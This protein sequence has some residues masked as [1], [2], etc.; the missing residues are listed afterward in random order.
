[1]TI[2]WKSV[3][4]RQSLRAAIF[5]IIGI[6]AGLGALDAAAREAG[7]EGT[8]VK[9]RTVI[10]AV[11][12]SWP[13][14]YSTDED[15]N[16]AGFAIDVMN[17]IAERAGIKVTYKVAEN[18]AGVSELM[19]RGE[20][21]LVP[22][23][24]VT[25]DRAANF[26][27]TIPVETF[28]VSIFVRSDTHDINGFADLA[29]R[30]V[31]VVRYNMGETLLRPRPEIKSK[32][33]P[34]LRV[35]LFELL[36]GHDD[37]LVF[38]KP[39][40]LR[41]AREIGVEDRIKTVGAPLQEIKR[42][43]RIQKSEPALAAALNIATEAFVGT[44]EY[45]R[46]Y[47]KWYGK[48]EPFWTVPR[49]VWG[50]VGLLAAVLL[51]GAGW[52]YRLVVKWGRELAAIIA[53]KESSEVALRVSESRFKDFAGAASDWFWEMG[54]DLRFTYHSERYFEI[55]GFRPEDMV[56][57]T[58]AHDVDAN[59]LA[60]D[61]E[62]WAVH[63]AE[64][65][66]HLPFKDFEFAFLV[67]D[68]SRRY[69]RVNGRP[70]FA[71]DGGFAG[72]RGTG[73]DVTESKLAQNALRDS[74]TSFRELV[75]SSLQ[76]VSVLD[77][78]QRFF[79]NRAYAEMLG[80][81]SPDDV[82]KLAR[83][84]DVF[85][86][87]EQQRLRDR[88]PQ[89][90]A[91]GGK[92][93]PFEADM[94]RKDGSIITVLGMGRRIQWYGKAAVLSF[95]VD[96]TERKRAEEALRDSERNFRAIAEGS[97]VSLLI[98]RRSDGTIL[99]AN[100]KVGPVLGLPTEAFKG[101]KI[102]EFFWQSDDRENRAATLEAQG[103]IADAPLE[104]RRADG[105]RISTIHCLQ[106]IN[107]AGENAILGSFQDVTDRL[108]LEEQLRQAQK[109][110][111]I[112]QLTGGVAHDF[113]NLLAVIMGNLELLVERAEA[114]S[115]IAKFA[116]RALAATGRG[117]N[118]THRL[119]AFSRRQ[120]LRPVSLDVSQ[121]VTGMQDLLLRTLGTTIE[122]A[123]VAGA[124]LWQC[125][126]DPGQLE[127]AIL[128]LSIN[129]RDAMPQGGRLT[130]EISNADLDD[131]Y[132]TAY[133][134]A[135]EDLAP[136][137]YVLLAISDTGSGMPPK[138]AAQAFEPFFTTKAVGKGS[139]LGL[140]MI[141]GFVKQSGGHVRIYSEVGAGTTI[142]IYLPR[143]AA[144]AGAWPETGAHP[145]ADTAAQGE[146]VMVV[147]DDAEVRMVVVGILDEL[148]YE[149]LQAETGDAAL[150]QIKHNDRINLLITDIALPGGM[151]GRELADRVR[152]ELLPGLKVLYISGYSED[153]NMRQGRLDDGTQLLTK[154]FR[155]AGLAIKVREILDSAL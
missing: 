98:T 2:S 55:T 62:K 117:A 78:S 10:A 43:I 83:T 74:E 111:A 89:R 84:S 92:S 120:P 68:G 7:K 99:Y 126:V 152:G 12:R 93:A 31:G 142:K 140:S 72:Y 3:V 52:R 82:M 113:N 73:A 79:V 56:G 46:L 127:N 118:L 96:I 128:N 108:R 13:P 64:L 119:L 1:M 17:E 125:E 61:A 66:A 94:L 145:V 130:I 110:E 97:P 25:P 132:A 30:R 40:L 16:P 139:G 95:V 63:A 129:A 60:A 22:N 77:E 149:V 67:R 6:V 28:V 154:P 49:I 153:A 91:S 59:D 18:F 112:G 135:P 50:V 151:D 36:A 109:M 121:L 34:E 85:P 58:V 144:G 71:N 134:T 53:E 5:A 37:A 14:Q 124:N 9:G 27:F 38:P 86:P 8:G 88:V 133:G 104:M 100:P 65:E 148:G 42:A 138:V 47:V 35:A 80:Y 15:G 4:R 107:Y 51:I 147:E 90:L 23:S 75:E 105:A 48:T 21:D 106:R 26:L 150:A 81:D 122:I 54:P 87:Y 70:V 114:D 141:Y 57:A 11:P 32:V 123:L 103:F 155:Q 137:Q 39:V 20:A 143:A 131:T 76:G 69:A 45:Q 19:N 44:P 24:G 41:F 116:A 33:H 115:E 136:G 101:R 29:G 102:S 146:V